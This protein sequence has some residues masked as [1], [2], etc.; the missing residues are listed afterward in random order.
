[1]HPVITAQLKEFS[2]THSDESL[3]QSEFFEVLSIHSIENGL[4]G[5][6][7][8]PFD[9]HLEASEFG[10]DGIAIILQGELCTNADQVAAA[11][12]VGK[13]H[14][15]GKIIVLNFTSF[16]QRH[17]RILTMVTSQSSSMQLSTFSEMG[18]LQK[19]LK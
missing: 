17:Q 18:I 14:S 12:S 11:L 8:D 6:N 3:K 1:M 19:A 2:D 15:L 10:I 4:M 9:A 7:I 16:N 5:L 13:N